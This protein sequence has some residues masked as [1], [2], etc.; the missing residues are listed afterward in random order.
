MGDVSVGAVIVAV[1]SAGGALA[2]GWILF[3]LDVWSTRRM[4]AVDD[5]LALHEA[6]CDEE[7]AARARHP[8]TRRITV[9]VDVFVCNGCGHPVVGP[10]AEHICPGWSS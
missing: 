2:V 1:L 4:G 6:I 8:A 5:W 3:R 9:P 7:A 10:S